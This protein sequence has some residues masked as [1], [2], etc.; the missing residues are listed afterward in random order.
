MQQF[1]GY[2]IQEPTLLN[3]AN[4]GVP[5]KR[6]RVFIV[7]IRQDLGK[8]FVFPEPTHNEEGTDGKSRGLQWEK[9]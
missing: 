1:E 3:A 7:G 4:Y 6:E 9:C 5:Q 8:T 2:S